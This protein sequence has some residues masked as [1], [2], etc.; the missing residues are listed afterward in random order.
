MSGYR[1]CAPDGNGEAR[2]DVFPVD[3]VE[4]EDTDEDDSLGDGV[5]EGGQPHRGESALDDLEGQ[6]GQEYAPDGGEASVRVRPPEDGDD[7]D[8]QDVGGAVV[9]RGRGVSRDEHDSRQRSEEA[10]EQVGAHQDARR[11]DAREPGGRPV[12]A[13]E[14]EGQAQRGAIQD[15]TDEEGDEAEDDE[16]EGDARDGR[17]PERCEGFGGSVEGLSSGPHDG[18][19]VEDLHGAQRG[20]DRGDA[21]VG[22]EEAVDEAAGEPH[23]Q[24]DEDDDRAPLFGSR[25]AQDRG[26]VERGDG[27]RA[28][29]GDCDQ[30]QVDAAGDHGDHH[31]DREDPDLRDREEHVLQVQSREEDAR[32]QDRERRD[33]DEEDEDHSADRPVA[34]EPRQQGGAQSVDAGVGFTK[35]RI[36]GAHPSTAWGAALL[37]STCAFLLR[38]SLV[39]RLAARA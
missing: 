35:C 31:R 18:Q 7:D 34:P 17:L 38:R 11:A 12:G 20:Q 27:D 28:Q 21:H 23:G 29:V 39:P 2:S 37:W 9:G 8:E 24:A 22:D 6:G 26:G 1:I 3:A 33:G 25:A 5:L 19:S 13:L 30:R 36:H 4:D 15:E 14:G 32:G 10:R 16:E